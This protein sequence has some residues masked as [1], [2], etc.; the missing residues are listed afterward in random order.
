[1]DVPNTYWIKQAIGLVCGLACG[2]TAVTAPPAFMLFG[3]LNALALAG[4][5]R[6]GGADV[7]IE[8]RWALAQDGLTAA[9]GMFLLTWTLAYSLLHH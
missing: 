1:M 5:M 3:S 8:R 4:V 2:V 6:G 7:S 9:L